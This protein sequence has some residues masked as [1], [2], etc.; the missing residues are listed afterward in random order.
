[1]HKLKNGLVDEYEN[2]DQ[3][4]KCLIV[5]DRAHFNIMFVCLY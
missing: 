2:S 4:V 5:P 3:Y 1:M